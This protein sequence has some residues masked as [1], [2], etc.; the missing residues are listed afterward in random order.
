MS[1]TAVTP[2][3]GVCGGLVEG[4][5]CYSDRITTTDYSGT[6]PRDVQMPCH[7]A[8]LDSVLGGK[9][10]ALM[11][12]RGQRPHAIAGVE[13]TIP[14]AERFAVLSKDP[15]RGQLLL[16]ERHLADTACGS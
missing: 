5:V 11:D 4:Q 14:A 7:W 8:C 10:V 15:V 16:I 9:V 13:E 12:H 1:S 6:A 3:C 2:N